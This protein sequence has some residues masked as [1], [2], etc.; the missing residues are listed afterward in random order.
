[1]SEK[2]KIPKN[3]KLPKI[4]GKTNSNCL[5]ITVFKSLKKNKGARLKPL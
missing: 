4:N 1:M 3:H 2:N 5:K